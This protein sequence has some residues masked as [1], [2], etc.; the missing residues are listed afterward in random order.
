MRGRSI[1]H[2]LG[3][4]LSTRKQGLRHKCLVEWLACYLRVM[5]SHQWMRW[6]TGSRGSRLAGVGSRSL[7]KITIELL[8]GCRRLMYRR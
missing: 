7:L 1:I 8:L 2:D 4:L 6:M 5:L 3:R